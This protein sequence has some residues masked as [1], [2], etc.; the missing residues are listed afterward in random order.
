MDSESGRYNRIPRFCCYLDF[1]FSEYQ[2][3][4]L[5]LWTARPHLH[6]SGVCFG[7]QILSRLLG[8]TVEPVSS[9]QWELGHSRVDLNEIGIKLFR[10][11]EPH[12]YL[13]QMHQDHVVA[14]PSSS[15]PLL[16]GKKVH[17]WGKSDHT[18]VQGLYV[19]NRLLTT[20]AHM[21]FDEDMVK[22]EIEMR[23]KNGAIDSGDKKEVERATETAGLEHDG[24]VVAAAL[25]RFW[26]YEDDG[27]DGN[28]ES[29]ELAL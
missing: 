18:A 3:N 2:A 24:E 12:I 9:E 21:A 17:V 4:D 7:H 28:S 26:A 11:D 6:F 27:I 15:H 29:E 13:H 1:D 19:Q 22:R 25:L 10:A 23:V 20:Q 5:D 14:P 16:N 8:C